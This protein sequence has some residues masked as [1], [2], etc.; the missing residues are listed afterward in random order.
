M[1]TIACE[2]A[3][4]VFGAGSGRFVVLFPDFDPGTIVPH[5]ILFHA[6]SN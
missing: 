1:F 6:F 3:D 5:G 4:W 2:D